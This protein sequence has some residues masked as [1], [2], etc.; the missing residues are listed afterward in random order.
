MTEMSRRAVLGASAAGAATLAVGL[1]AGA[2]AAP[3]VRD[4]YTRRRFTRLRG[5]K[6]RLT[7]AAGSWTVKLTHVKDLEHAARG[8][9]RSFALTFRR[10]TPGPPQG[11]YTLRRPGFRPTVIFVVPSDRR[12]RTYEVVVN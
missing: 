9:Q 3:D 6:F 7:S 5:R 8:E 12:R 1:P 10:G 11:T 2:A 4:L